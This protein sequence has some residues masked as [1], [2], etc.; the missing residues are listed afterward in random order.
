MTIAEGSGKERFKSH[1]RKVGS[2]EHTSKGL[3]REEAAEALDLMLHQEAT[4][5]QIGAFL[6][7][8]RIL[9]FP[10]VL[11]AIKSMDGLPVLMAQAI[12]FSGNKE[13]LLILVGMVSQ[14]RIALLQWEAFRMVPAILLHLANAWLFVIPG[15]VPR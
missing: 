3:S 6:I 12:C 1:L 9:P 7:A 5:A 4:P 15:M 10:T 13:S 14:I 8:H 2:G 11:E